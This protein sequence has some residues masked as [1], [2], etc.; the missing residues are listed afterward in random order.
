MTRRVTARDLLEL[1]ID[2]GSW[3][4]WD[5][6]PDH[7]D[8]AQDYEETLTRAEKRAG[9]DESVVTGSATIRG[10]R[11]AL[12]VSEFAFLGGS[13]GAA[14]AR[15]IEAAVR[16]S[17]AERLPLVAAPASGGTRVQ[18]GTPAFVMIVDIARA[19][20][21]HKNSGLLYLTYLRN[22]TTGGV[23]ASWGS[24]GHITIVEPNALIGF[25]GPTVCEALNQRPFPEGIQNA[26]HLVS[27]GVVDSVLAPEQL[28]NFVADVLSVVVETAPEFDESSVTAPTA[29]SAPADAWSS[30]IVTRNENRPGLRELIRF[31]ADAIVPQPLKSPELARAIFCGLATFRGISC[32]LIG[33]DRQAQSD[34]RSLKPG[35]LRI[36]RSWMRTAERFGL[37][38]VCVVDTPGADLS[39]ESE[40]RGMAREISRTVGALVQLRVPTLSV[41]LGEGCGGGALALLPAQHVVAAENAWLSP[42]PPE[43]AS[44]ILFGT[45][46]RATEMARSQKIT[47]HDLYMSGVVHSIIP[48]SLPAHE[49]PE[50]FC[51]NAVDAIGM[52][53]GKLQRQ[54][55][56]SRGS[57][58]SC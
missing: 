25:L 43:G 32:V 10:R 45:P 54:Y 36:A 35:D 16:R 46:E 9:T 31:G 34:G 11:V 14:A 19:L 15:R 44:T 24:M 18:E 58:L 6:A 3:D 27:E 42:L 48:E 28:G 30:I 7:G 50:R 37:P 22:P 2:A 13:I 17:T 40:E 33:Q 56:A 4:S 47:S 12:I 57:A 26:E 52:Q 49:D 5:V 51:E 21:D 53:L 8:I 1:T 39:A 29:P 38:V 23:L 41:L 55:V 20:V